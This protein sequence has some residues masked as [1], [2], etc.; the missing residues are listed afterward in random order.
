MTANW[1]AVIIGGGPAGLSA[2]VA[3][4]RSRRSVLVI[5][6]GTPRN[7][8][9]A[10]MHGVL[11]HEGK[12]PAEL[13]AAG[14]AEAALYGVEVRE[15]RVD[16]VEERTGGGL[17]A[18]LADGTTVGAR[19]VVLATG[20]VDDLPDI[21]GLAERWGRSVLHCPFCH[22][23]EVRE[24]PLGVLATSP[25][26]L[27]QAFLL[28]QWTDDLTFFAAAAGELDDA[29][30]RRLAARDVRVVTEPVV[31]VHGGDLDRIDTVELADGTRVAV[32]ALFTGGTPRPL[33][34]MLAPLGLDRV[35]GPM[36]DYLAVDPMTH[37]TSHPRVFAAG[38]VTNPG[39]NVSM[40][41]GAGAMAGAQLTIALVHDD[42][43]RA[44]AAA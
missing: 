21:P 38:N 6:E 9:A 20:L 41:L 19:G 4:G 10:H 3:L 13:A 8:F 17:V 42:F 27:H 18:R 37:R 22:G 12:A 34:G 43:D 39:V 30:L 28:R 33:D 2:A 25:M 14:R 11:G 15:G 40:A 35:T 1:D 23:W 16:R 31:A 7:R 5:D 32:D 24:R 36:G 29:T 44:E 26:S